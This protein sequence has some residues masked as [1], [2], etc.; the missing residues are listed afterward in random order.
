MTGRNFDSNFT[1]FN[2]DNDLSHDPNDSKSTAIWVAQD[3]EARL[4]TCNIRGQ[5]DYN[6]V[7]SE[8]ESYWSPDIT[9]LFGKTYKN[10]GRMSVTLGSENLTCY[11]YGG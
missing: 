10:S 9:N 8:L 5:I 1:T 11:N 4:S 2:K 3:T 6:E 7:N